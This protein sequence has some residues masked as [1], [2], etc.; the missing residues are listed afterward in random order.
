MTGA[1][2]SA[3]A[4]VVSW[5]LLACLATVA[6]AAALRFTGLSLDLPFLYHPDEPHNLAVVQRLVHSGSA[7]P[8]RFNYPS[9]FYY[10]YLPSQLAVQAIAGRLQDFVIQSMGNGFTEQPAA[11]IAARLT[12]ASVGTG[13]VVLTM[14]LARAVVVSRWAIL[15][16]GAL[17][18]ANP[19]LVSHSRMVTPDVPAAFFVTAALIAAVRIVASASLSSYVVGGA[20]A[21]FAAATKYNAGLVAIAI[22]AGHLLNV[23]RR[24]VR[25]GRLVVAGAV[26]IVAF[27]LTVPYLLLDFPDVSASILAEMHHYRTGHPGYEGHSL[28]TNLAWLWT[29]FGAPLVLIVA[30]ALHPARLRLIPVA[31]FAAGY[32][33]LLAVQFVRFERNL[34]P[35]VPALIV[36]IAVGFDVLRLGLS[37]RWPLEH[38]QNLLLAMLAI[39]VVAPGFLATAHETA[40]SY[41]ADPRREARAWVLAQVAPGAAVMEEPYTIFTGPDRYRVTT[42]GFVLKKPMDAIAASDVV[43][44][45]ARGS[46]RFLRGGPDDE[47]DKFRRIGER[48]CERKTFADAAGQAAIWVFRLHC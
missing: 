47:S 46:G 6:L 20:M 22:A 19:L 31:V 36:L 38:A 39:A 42:G 43:V 40:L 13:L 45:S 33:A 48:A 18:A 28:A 12:T 41:G 14:L 9:L 23:R 34:I 27:V 44:L 2:S 25:L 32:F 24:L 29:I 37:R 26:C 35:L 16:A 5:F 1:A 4:S 21:G 15:L 8:H 30:A 10:L 17:A 7:N 3:R 11:F